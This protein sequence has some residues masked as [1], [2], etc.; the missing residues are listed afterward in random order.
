[1]TCFWDGIIRSLSIDDFNLLGFASKP[2]N[3]LFISRLKTR[4]ERVDAT[5]QNCILSP[6]EMDE[7]YMAIDSYDIKKIGH[8]HLTS[9]CDSFLLLLCHILHL[10]I[11]HMYLR[12]LIKY[13]Y[14]GGCSRKILSFQSS[15]THFSTR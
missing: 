7:H 6:K 9:S 4:N 11:N 15:R 3:E 10:D 8:G 2:T 12:F 5:W 13:R 14:I 1:M